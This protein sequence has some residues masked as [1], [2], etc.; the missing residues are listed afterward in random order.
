M[1]KSHLWPQIEFSPA[2][3]WVPASHMAHGMCNLS[4][5]RCR[6]MKTGIR[7]LVDLEHITNHNRVSVVDNCTCKEVSTI[8]HLWH[9]W[10]TP[11]DLQEFVVC[12]RNQHKHPWTCPKSFWLGF[13]PANQLLQAPL[14][15]F[16]SQT[17][18]ERVEHGG[19]NCVDN[20]SHS[21][22]NSVPGQGL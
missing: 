10:I 12:I 3:A 13:P 6:Y 21:V 2:E 1:I 8:K 19:Q 17:V 15:V 20:C 22:P 4:I 11:A 14:H 5:R 18:D 7:I 9:T 16:V